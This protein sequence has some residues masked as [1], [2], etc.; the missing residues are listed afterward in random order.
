MT[1]DRRRQLPS[2]LA[3]VSNLKRFDTSDL[4]ALVVDDLNRHHAQA[5][6]VIQCVPEYLSV[7]A[8]LGGVCLQVLVTRRFLLLHAP[9]N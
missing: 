3:T 4:T 7:A 9:R 2:V 5:N 6:S 8:L 1:V